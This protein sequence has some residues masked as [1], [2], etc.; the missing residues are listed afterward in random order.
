[1]LELIISSC[2]YALPVLLYVFLY[3]LYNLS[4][5]IWW[6]KFLKS[7]VGDVSDLYYLSQFFMDG[8]YVF[9]DTQIIK[10]SK[11]PEN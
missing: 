5:C 2:D 1:M 9:L 10:S 4:R 3:S 11:P 7:V 6:I 8:C